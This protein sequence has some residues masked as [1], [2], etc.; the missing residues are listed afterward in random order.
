M[1]KNEAFKILGSDTSEASYVQKLGM[2]ADAEFLIFIKG[3][4]LINYILKYI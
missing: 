4:I 1:A 3:F 2:F